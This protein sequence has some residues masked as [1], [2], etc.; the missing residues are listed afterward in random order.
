MTDLDNSAEMAET[1]ANAP[2]RGRPPR[3]Q[4]PRD[5]AAQRAAELRSHLSNVSDGTD[6]F[7]IDLDSIPDGW[8][9]EWKTH[10]IYNQDQST[11]TT[12]LLREGWTPVPSSR[13]PSMMPQ[14]SGD[15]PIMRKGMMLMECPTE[16]IR[17]RQM[18]AKR[19]AR[20]QVRFKEEQLGATPTGTLPRD[21]DPRIRP[22][23]KSHFEP[24]AIP[25]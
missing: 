20:D 6:E 3:E 19:K 9:Y 15:A 23:V 5:R 21:A 14:G 1:S 17:E 4:S 16:I 13:H 22:K 8:T 11:Y 7:Y 18:D 25:E 10:S 2:R 12:Q 24:M